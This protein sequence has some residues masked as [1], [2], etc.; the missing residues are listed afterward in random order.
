MQIQVLIERDGNGGYRATTAPPL[1][2]SGATEEEA[3]SRLRELLACSDNGDRRIVTLDSPVAHEHMQRYFGT[4]KDH[5]LLDAWK[6][7]MAA[8]RQRVENDP[9]Y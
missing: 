6:E 2:A 9:D 3:L 7:E 1:T 8:Y 4:L 5:P